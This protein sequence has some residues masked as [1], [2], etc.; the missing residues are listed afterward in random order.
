MM[1]LSFVNVSHKIIFKP[2]PNWRG[3][4][5]SLVMRLMLK[6]SD[7]RE[8]EKLT[9]DMTWQRTTRVSDDGKAEDFLLPTICSTLRCPK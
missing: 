1:I 5:C 3:E 4:S 2:F 9:Y 8:F 6:G 7:L